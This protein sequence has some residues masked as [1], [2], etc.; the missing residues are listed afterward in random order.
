MSKPLVYRATNPDDE[1][2][3]WYVSLNSRDEPIAMCSEHIY[4]VT[5]ASA[6][7]AAFPEF[8]LE[9]GYADAVKT[10]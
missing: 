8:D 3:P 5:F 2:Y 1:D 10:P 4:A 7:G 6:I 9:A